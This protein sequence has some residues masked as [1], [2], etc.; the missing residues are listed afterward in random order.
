MKKVLIGLGVIIGLYL[1]TTYPGY[2][3]AAVVL[4]V[5]GFIAYKVV[6]KRKAAPATPAAQISAPA[7]TDPPSPVLPRQLPRQH[8]SPRQKS[9]KLTSEATP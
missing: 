4:A 8:R 9:Q 5:G 2:V 6:K 1:I 3:I 7:S